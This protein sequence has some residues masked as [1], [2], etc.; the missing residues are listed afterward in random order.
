MLD[1]K[2]Q[3]PFFSKHP[4]VVYLDSAATTQKPSSVID[5]LTEF[6]TSHNANAGRSSYALANKLTK[7]IEQIRTKAQHFINA[8]DCQEIIFTTGATDSFNKMAYSLGTNYLQDG[9]EILYCPYDHKSFVLPWFNVQKLLKNKGVNIK[10]VSFNVTKMGSIDR[11]DLFS[12]ITPQTKII[13]ATHVHNI[14]GADSDIDEIKK[15][16]GDQDIII[17]VDAA[18]SI[19][20]IPVDV[21]KLG[22]DILSFSGH[23]MFAS[24]GIGVLYIAKHLQQFTPPVFTGGGNGITLKNENIEISNFVQSYEAGTQNYAGIITLG[25][26]IDFIENIGIEKIH[27]HLSELTQYLLEKLKQLHNIEFVYGPYYWNCYDG[28]GIMSFKI[29]GISP[30][31][32]GFILAEQGILVRTGDHCISTHDEFDNTIRVSM[33]IYNTKNDVDTLV[34]ALEKVT[35]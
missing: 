13:N 6:Y 1:I 18:Q 32:L 20:H 5:A 11:N 4:D 8:Q 7:Q 12:K 35:R 34:Q 33:H 31:E 24:Q 9:D 23:K 19:G 28:M 25:K 10:L 17:N 30:N 2:S 29:N 14:Y 26:A 22:A 27:A 15:H 16:I 3:F 21:Q